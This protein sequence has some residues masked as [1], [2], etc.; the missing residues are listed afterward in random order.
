M[1]AP[2]AQAV[3]VS[4]QDQERVFREKHLPS[5]VTKCRKTWSSPLLMLFWP[6]SGQQRS[7]MPLRTQ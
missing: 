7:L 1:V 6:G 2:E 4:P 5:R 3:G